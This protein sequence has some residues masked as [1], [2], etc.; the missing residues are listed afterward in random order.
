MI[1]HD[2]LHY[3]QNPSAQS[4]EAEADEGYAICYRW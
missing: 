3:E 4:L 1:F 2:L